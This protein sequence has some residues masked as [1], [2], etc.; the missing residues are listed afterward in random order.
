MKYTIVSGQFKTVIDRGSVGKAALDAINLWKLKTI[1]P[2]LA[3]I[4]TVISPN[5]QETYLLTSE[6]I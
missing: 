2:I 6:L 3:K 5:K 4:T 1:K